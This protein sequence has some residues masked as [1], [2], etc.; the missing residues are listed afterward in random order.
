M[1]IAASVI[2]SILSLQ[3]AVFARAGTVGYLAWGTYPA[4]GK[5]GHCGGGFQH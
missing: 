3:I 2:V 1:V 5:K 4:K